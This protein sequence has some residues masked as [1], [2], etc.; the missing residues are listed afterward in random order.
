[1]KQAIAALLFAAALPVYAQVPSDAGEGMVKRLD[2]DGNGTVSEA[3]LLAPL[4]EKMKQEFSAMDAD[5]DGQVTAD[6]A[7]D[8]AEQMFKKIQEHHQK[9]PQMPSSPQQ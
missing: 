4:Q 6:E 7:Q 8:F 2:T 1:M 9:M 3:E 5:H